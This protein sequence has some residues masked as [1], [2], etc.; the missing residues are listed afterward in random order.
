[1]CSNGVNIHQLSAISSI[2]VFPHVIGSVLPT[3]SAGTKQTIDLW[4]PEI[5]RNLYQHFSPVVT[6]ER[7][8][9]FQIACLFYKSF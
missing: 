2:S 8:Q 6:T 4:P 5:Q 7:M 3:Y 9:H 1:M